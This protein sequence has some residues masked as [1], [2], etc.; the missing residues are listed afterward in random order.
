MSLT[1]DPNVLNDMPQEESDDYF[2]KNYSADHRTFINDYLNE[3]F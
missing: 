1:P 3:E 2:W